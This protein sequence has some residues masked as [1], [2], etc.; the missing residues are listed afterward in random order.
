MKLTPSVFNHCEPICPPSST[1]PGNLF[2]SY[3]GWNRSTWKHPHHPPFIWIPLSPWSWIES[4]DHFDTNWS[5]SMTLR[6]LNLISCVSVWLLISTLYCYLFIAYNLKLML[7]QDVM[8][9]LQFEIRRFGAVNLNQLIYH[10][11]V[12]FV[13]LTLYC[14]N[15]VSS[16]PIRRS[17]VT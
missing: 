3:C 5:W 11:R 9:P 14:H 12:L 8:I 17:T 4:N 1:S 16:A 7:F 15:R 6:N 10:L 2:G 13:S